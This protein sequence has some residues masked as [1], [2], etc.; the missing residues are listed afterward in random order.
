VKGVITRG[1]LFGI[2]VLIISQN[3][4]CYIDCT[5]TQESVIGWCNYQA[6][7]EVNEVSPQPIMIY[8]NTD[9]TFILWQS[10][11]E[12][13]LKSSFNYRIMFNNG[14]LTETMI[15]AEFSYGSPYTIMGIKTHVAAIDHLNRLNFLYFDKTTSKFNH[16]RYEDHSWVKI[17]D[18][19]V[20]YPVIC[21]ANDK[22]NNLHLIYRERVDDVDNISERIFNGLTWSESQQIT[23]HQKGADTQV[24]FTYA[25]DFDAGNDGEIAVVFKYQEFFLND[26]NI[27]F[28]HCLTYKDSWE[29]EVVAENDT[30][31]GPI[32][33][34]D[35]TGTLY[36]AYLS[37]SKAYEMYY[38]TYQ[39]N[40]SEETKLVVSWPPG[41]GNIDLSI[42][43]S[44]IYLLNAVSRMSGEVLSGLTRIYKLE[45]DFLEVVEFVYT[46]TETE[47]VEESAVL[48]IPNG[49]LYVITNEYDQ[50]WPATYTVFF[51]FKSNFYT[52]CPETET[53]VRISWHGFWGFFIILPV[54][55]FNKKR[56]KSP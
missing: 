41:F 26:S 22:D 31:P 36:V 24:I 19:V 10:N 37:D 53:S 42:Y 48:A 20:L 4:Q 56:K 21:L 38:R 17:S 14:T 43:G 15:I 5:L 33:E 46:S 51:G 2:L 13:A 28:I 18:V 29:L 34:F 8:D 3:P 12:T 11:D 23:S 40:W 55:I 35:D 7:S 30:L 47:P 27:E 49:N 45:N 52:S 54:L 25:S 16:V 39:N 32:C 50:E 9:K 44:S 1:I 6:I